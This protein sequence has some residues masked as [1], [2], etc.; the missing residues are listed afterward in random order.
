MKIRD[1]K[2]APVSHI[3]FLAFV[4]GVGQA[5]VVEFALGDGPCGRHVDALEVEFNKSFLKVTQ[6]STSSD[7]DDY[8][9]KDFIYK[10]SDVTGR[11]VVTR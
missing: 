7:P 1:Q 11:I 4:P 10:M 9:I 2:E 6:G 8:E 3:R 5:Q